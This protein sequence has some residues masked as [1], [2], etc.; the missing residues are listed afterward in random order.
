M[1]KR[2]QSYFTDNIKGFIKGMLHWYV[3]INEIEGNHEWKS[4][5][6]K[7]WFDQIIYLWI[8]FKVL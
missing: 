7:Y 4:F 8:S 3:N 5:S 2:N 6:I 1:G